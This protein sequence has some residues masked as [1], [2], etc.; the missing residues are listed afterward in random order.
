MGSADHALPVLVSLLRDPKAAVLPPEG[1]ALDRLVDL[2]VLHRVPGVV[3]EALR[4]AGRDLPDSLAS[5]LSATRARYLQNLR[6]LERAG[7]ALDLAGLRWVVVKG[8][9]LAARWHEDPTARPSDD[10]DL[11]VDPEH[12]RDAVD[13]LRSAGFEDRNRNWGGFRELGVGEVPLSDGA[14]V[15]DLHWHL[16]GLLRH[17]RDFALTTRE[18]LD[19]S[20]ELQL[21]GFATRS[22]DDEDTLV[23]LCLHHALAGSRRLGHLRD[24]HAVA[25]SVPA[26]TGVERVERARAQ[27]LVAAVLARA[28]RVLGPIDST[29]TTSESVGSGAWVAFT[30]WVDLAWARVD[31]DGSEGFPGAFVAAGRSTWPATARAF[32]DRVVH[33]LKGKVGAATVVSDGG[34]LD[35]SHPSGG[36]AERE[37][38]FA[39]VAAGRYGR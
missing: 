29:G 19:R 3:A 35:W 22:L 18:L 39:D 23:H 17:R 9:V 5:A 16:I 1:P 7:A 37:R 24:V 36:D 12:L 14:M 27:R 32:G 6:A 34:P 38:F 20:I 8:P 26:A 28:E 11:L 25:A 10:L 30:R 4:I 2:A 21:G 31:P 33:N 15:I 13:A